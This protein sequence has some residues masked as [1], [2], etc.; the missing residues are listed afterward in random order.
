MKQQPGDE[1][2]QQIAA[3]FNS[4][5]ERYDT[6]KFF[7][8][9]AGILVDYLD[10]DQTKSMLDVST[11]TGAIAITAAGRC[12]E[13]QVEA[14]DLSL[15]MMNQAKRKAANLDI[16][17][18]AFRLMDA[19]NLDYED[20]TF[21]IITCGYG[22]FFYPEMETAFAKICSK[23]KRGGRFV[24]STFAKEAFY[25]YAEKFLELL[26]KYGVEAPEMSR[27]R[28]QEEQ[29]IRTLCAQAQ[30]DSILVDKHEI[31]YEVTVDDW[32]ALINNGGYKSLLDQVE[33]Q[34]LDEFRRR[35][36]EQ[37]HGLSEDGKITLNAD[38]LYGIAGK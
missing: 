34:K 32:W 24:F 5:A 15:E 33:P 36:L 21:D 26:K 22:L 11:G 6:N 9:S 12:P 18:I 25:P 37:I 19:E 10:L 31:R 27:A 7:S 16:T 3:T 29:Q 23:L 4:V 2:K 13:M 30:A 8:I 14:V 1:R 38:S 17:N 20:G 28:L 35:H